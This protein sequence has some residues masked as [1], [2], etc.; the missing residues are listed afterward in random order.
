MAV[1]DEQATWNKEIR[2][3]EA[4]PMRN[5]SIRLRALACACLRLCTPVARKIYSFEIAGALQ[6][7]EAYAGVHRRT[8]AQFSRYRK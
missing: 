4:E 3:Q 7:Y 2:W 1:T 6:A 8:K 5:A